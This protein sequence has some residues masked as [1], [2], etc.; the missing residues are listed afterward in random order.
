MFPWMCWGLLDRYFDIDHEIRML[1]ILKIKL[2]CVI[3][4]FV[5]YYMYGISGPSILI[6]STDSMMRV[7]MSIQA[8]LVFV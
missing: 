7:D 3:S 8:I 2:L 4:V 6:E 5:L 1:K